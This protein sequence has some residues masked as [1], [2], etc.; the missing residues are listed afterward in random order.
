MNI[1]RSEVNRALAKA[2]AYKQC[3]KDYE[4][5]VWAVE[6]IRLLDC[7]DVLNERP[8]PFAQ[9]K[10]D[11]GKAI[12]QTIR[13]LKR[14]GTVACGLAHLRMCVRPPAGGPTGTNAQWIYAQMFKEAVD[15]SPSRRRF[16]QC[17]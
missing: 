5:E 7:A 10:A 13:E 12:D 3:G 6:L 16:V 8:D 4:A 9:W 14:D 11:L 17:G 15:A 1:D 2:I